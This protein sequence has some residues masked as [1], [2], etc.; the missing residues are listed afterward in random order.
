MQ[1]HILDLVSEKDR[2]FVPMHIYILEMD[3]H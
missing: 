2:K 3:S 1:S